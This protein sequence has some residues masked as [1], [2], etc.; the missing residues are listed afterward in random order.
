[1]VLPATKDI[2]DWLDDQDTT[3][4]MAKK[5]QEAHKVMAVL[6][7]SPARTAGLVLM[8]LTVHQAV[9][10]RQELKDVTVL[11]EARVRWD[12]LDQWDLVDSMVERENKD[13]KH[14]LANQDKMEMMAL[15]E[16]WVTPA[17]PET[18]VRLDQ[19]VALAVQ[20]QLAHPA[21]KD[22]PVFKVHPVVRDLLV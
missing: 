13:H 21:R 12:A 18:P 14:S 7:A 8:D 1:M 16:P 19:V 20:V 4:R 6:T 15:M 5:D 17:K 2:K 22:H 11:V 10:E 3:A 9:L